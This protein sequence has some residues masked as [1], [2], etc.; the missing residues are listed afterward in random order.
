MPKFTTADGTQLYYTDN[1]DGLPVLAL[2]G[3]TR[4]TADF[5]HVAPHLNCRLIRMDYRGRGA[6][7]WADP[8]S[9][10]IPHEAMDA[11]ALRPDRD[12]FGGDCQTPP[13]WRG[14]QRHRAR[15]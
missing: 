15:D 14:P 1:G 7:D 13:S 2:A 5:D 12:G 3:L 11:I 9:Y 4:N 6:S 10:T 8:A